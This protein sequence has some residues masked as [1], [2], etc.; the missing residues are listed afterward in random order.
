MVL[1]Y[2]LLDPSFLT[3]FQLVSL[4]SCFSNTETLLP[5]DG[6]PRLFTFSFRLLSHF[7]S[8]SL[9]F[10]DKTTGNSTSFP[11]LLY[12]TSVGGLRPLEFLYL[13]G[14]FGGPPCIGTTVE[15]KIGSL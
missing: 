8:P 14:D 12:L 3:P 7:Q 13:I 10:Y 15:L 9:N 11:G 6:G 4:L 2:C 1:N 5:T